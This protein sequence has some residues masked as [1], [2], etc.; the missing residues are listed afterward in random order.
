[1]R[2]KRRELF[3]LDYNGLMEPTEVTSGQTIR[4]ATMMC[5]T[6]PAPSPN[7]SCVARLPAR[8]ARPTQGRAPATITYPSGRVVTASNDDAGRPIGVTST[9]QHLRN[10][11][12]GLG[13][14]Y[15]AHGDIRNVTLGAGTNAVAQTRTYDGK[16]EPL[17]ITVPF[18]SQNQ[19]TGA[20]YDNAGNMKSAAAAHWSAARA[21]PLRDRCRAS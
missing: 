9:T 11:A 6:V 8:S 15:A 18:N 10:V 13:V 16:L 3:L 17:T 14:G 2:N 21:A 1:V 7:P 12:S 5:S 4:T 20:S 19:Y